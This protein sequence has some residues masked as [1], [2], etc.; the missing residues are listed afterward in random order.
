MSDE[1]GPGEMRVSDAERGQVQ[2]R[3]HRAH[4][5]GQLD[6]TEFDDRVRAVWA[7]RTRGELERLSADLPPAVPEQGRRPAF[8]STG[9]GVA[10]RVLTIVWASLLAVNLVIWGLVVLVAGEAV[11]P[12]WIWVAGPGAALAVL[13]GFGI[14]RPPRDG[15]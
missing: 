4:A 3:L 10:M 8:S 14:G 13:Y 15:R 11:H 6:L 5:D 9:G 12:W 2:D 7:A 1:L